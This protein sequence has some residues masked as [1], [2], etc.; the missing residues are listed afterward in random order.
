MRAA[1][2]LVLVLVPVVAVAKQPALHDIAWYKA[3]DKARLLTLRMC[4][5]NASLQSASD[6]CENAERA[7]A[8]AVFKGTNKHPLSYL[9]NPAYWTA[10]PLARLGELNAC[11][12]AE[13]PGNAMSLPFCAAAR[14]SQSEE[15]GSR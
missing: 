9:Y 15:A 2:V 6:D 13:D 1:L 3:N 12:H 8:T 4:H 5:G 11:N 10:N 7:E 14:Q